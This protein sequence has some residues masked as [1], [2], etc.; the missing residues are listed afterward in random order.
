MKFYFQEDDQL[1]DLSNDT[2]KEP[3]ARKPA[4]IVPS[5]N[6]KSK[7]KK[8][9][10]KQNSKAEESIDSI[11]EELSMNTKASGNNSLRENANEVHYSGKKN[12]VPS[13]LAVDPKF[14]KAEN[15]LRKIFGSKVVNSF[16][17][18]RSVGSSRQVH[19]GKR[20]GYNFRKTFLATPLGHWPRWDN[21]LTMELLETKDGVQYFRY[22]FVIHL[23]DNY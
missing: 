3:A 18:Q 15:E 10:S 22:S 12:G 6:Q 16:E 1:Q 7:K 8:K 20:A 14:L 23:L 4:G 2:V 19:G 9:K 5:S 13:I 17:N 21:S 11:L